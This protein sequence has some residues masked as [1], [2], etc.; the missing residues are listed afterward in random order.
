MMMLNQHGGGSKPFAALPRRI[1]TGEPAPADRRSTGRALALGAPLSASFMGLLLLRGDAAAAGESGDEPAAGSSTGRDVT[2]AGSGG[3]AG[4]G[5]LS[6][7]AMGLG[8][9]SAAAATLV[10]DG[11]VI[12]AAALTALGE[13]SAVD[14]EALD[15]AAEAQPAE[16]GAAP[17]S[18]P[19]VPPEIGDVTIAFG[20]EAPFELPTYTS[21]EPGLPEENL[22][23]LGDPRL[24]DRSP[25]HADAGNGTDGQSDGGG[26]GG[27]STGQAGTPDEAVV[28]LRIT[29]T[30]G[31]DYLV[32]SDGN[33]VIDAVGG[34]NTVLAGAG[35]DHVIGGLGND[36]LHGG[37]GNDTIEGRAGQNI[38]YGDEGDDRLFGGT[39]NDKLYGGSGNDRLD[40]VAGANRLEGGPGDD[41]LV[42][43]GPRDIAIETS[44]GGNDTLEVA[45]GFGAALRGRFT[46]L[47]PDGTATFVIGDE[48]GRTFPAEV[49]GYLYQLDPEVENVR[50]MGSD[51]HDV[52][53]DSNANVITGNDGDNLLYGGSGDDILYAGGGNDVLRG[54]T[55]NDTLYAGAGHDV[56]FG[57]AG[58]DV[59]YGGA[60]ESELHGGEGDDLYVFGLAEGGRATVFD[61]EGS[62]RLRF[63]GPSDPTALGAR[64]EGDDLVLDDAGADV[65]RIADYAGH[66]DAFAG[67]EVGGE[68]VSLDR[69][70]EA[71]AAR[72]AAVAAGDDLLAIYLGPQSVE[73]DG[74]IL[75]PARLGEDAPAHDAPFALYEDTGASGFEAA[76][77][78]TDAGGAGADDMIGSFMRAEP[79]WIGPE[80]GVF[81]PDADDLR[82]ATGD[83]AQHAR[84]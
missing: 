11:G 15:R 67:L 65:V 84:A 72:A 10:G 81:V 2:S 27:S 76:A 22:G 38:I 44:G 83:E 32:G 73:A 52:L 7:A 35:D 1:D 24:I 75:D 45:S 21:D 54:D 68:T 17:E 3:D 46:T 13:A 34:R 59:L 82:G 63:D 37:P 36:T 53:G 80:E 79:L 43:N 62:N 69:F 5:A 18:V 9:S 47:A 14:A 23:D 16:H 64:L 26:D 20:S 41:T 55:G 48:P 71:T 49:N 77:T 33:D 50:L 66:R 61:H 29:G 30:S 40:G 8:I 58:D 74:D 19:P 39:G 51:N 70:L 12:D 28:G 6:L 42:I 78:T 25:I 31:G 56:L 4:A 60:G 57:E